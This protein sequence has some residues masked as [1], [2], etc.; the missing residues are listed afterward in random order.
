VRK[1]TLVVLL[2]A[3]VG[4]EKY[5]NS[6]EHE[7]CQLSFYIPIT[8][9]FMQEKENCSYCRVNPN[10]IFQKNEYGEIVWGI[11]TECTKKAFKKNFKE[12]IHKNRLAC[13]Y[14]G[15]K[16]YFILKKD[17]TLK[18]KW[19]C[20]LLCFKR[21]FN[22]V[23]GK[24]K[25]GGQ[26]EKPSDQLKFAPAVRCSYCQKLFQDNESYKMGFETDKWAICADCAKTVFDKSLEVG[27][28]K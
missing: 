15:R 5:Q 16:S 10:F 19:V 23:L 7:K 4:E 13:S 27:N 3:K 28:A 25:N 20:C 18:I 14:C 26:V 22:K 8:I 11:C 24:D 6:L 9:N 21:F 1:T 12:R 2:T 17:V